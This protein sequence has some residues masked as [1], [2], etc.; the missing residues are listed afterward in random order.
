MIGLPHFIAA[1][2]PLPFFGAGGIAA[3]GMFA[4]LGT[5]LA[6]GMQKVWKETLGTFLR[7]LAGWIDV[8]I[9]ARFIHIRP[10]RRV[11][12]LIRAADQQVDNAFANVVLKGEEASAWCFSTAGHM[13]WWAV[14]ETADLAHDVWSAFERTTVETIPKAV[15]RAEAATLERLR[16]ID[17]TIG[18]IEAMARA[19]L[20]RLAV[21]I[22]RLG[23]RLA[24]QITHA[25]QGVAARVGRLERTTKA[26]AKRIARAEA[27]WKTHAVTAAVAVA[28]ARL[29][30][31]WLRCPSLSR[32]GRKVGCRG[33][34]ALEAFLSEA[35]EALVVLD[36]CRFALAAQ[37]LARFVV[38]QLGAVL[39]V[40]NAVC[41]GGGASLPS[42]SDRPRI[43]TRI[44]LPS[45][46]D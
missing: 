34:G 16:G 9:N 15:R 2:E 28:L 20:A 43:S 33:F 21:G 25:V 23:H 4:L 6:M 17:H 19:Q 40:Q 1:A 29:G 18:R 26:E 7:H 5:L 27:K 39:L 32:I 36:L 30:L 45:A 38:P 44:T 35:F 37:R 42:A 22:D 46:H 41:L 13:F 10:F 14:H 31:N 24:A 8:D 12:N 3:L 11:A